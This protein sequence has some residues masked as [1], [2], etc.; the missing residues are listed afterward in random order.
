MSIWSSF[1]TL[2]DD[3]APFTDSRD[4]TRHW[5]SGSAES[6]SSTSR[7]GWIDLASSSMCGL[8]RIMSAI[9]D[10][11]P[12]VELFLSRDQVQAL[13]NALDEQLQRGYLSRAPIVATPKRGQAQ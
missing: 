7:G 1:M 9:S 10:D 13:R 4:G 3:D 6:L 12:E 8:L 5:A 11:A 2:D